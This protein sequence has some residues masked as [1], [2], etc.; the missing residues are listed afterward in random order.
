M[1]VDEATG[2]QFKRRVYVEYLVLGKPNIE[3][4]AGFTNMM[5]YFPTF[6]DWHHWKKVWDM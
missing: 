1:E 3:N 2:Q 6:R 4:A 5:P